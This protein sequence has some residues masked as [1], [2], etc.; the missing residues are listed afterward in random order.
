MV[1]HCI[2]ADFSRAMARGFWAAGLGMYLL[3]LAGMWDVAH[4]GAAEDILSLNDVYMNTTGMRYIPFV[5]CAVPMAYTFCEDWDNQFV[6]SAVIRA[7]VG[8][9]AA[10]RTAVTALAGGGA[11]V[12]GYVL[13]W[14]T[15]TIMG[16]P[17]FAG[18]DFSTMAGMADNPVFGWMLRDGYHALL[19][20]CQALTYGAGFAM[21]AVFALW[22]STRVPNPFVVTAAPVLLIIVLNFICYLFRIPHWYSFEGIFFHLM[23][24]G[25]LP[26]W[27]MTAIPIL[28]SAILCGLMGSLFADGVKRRLH[29]G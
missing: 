22:I 19:L 9:Y 26:A 29:H 8:R 13:Y 23:L 28:I 21:F 11:I 5:L 14:I 27:A 10:A 15:L 6:R 1:F 3:L 4:I 7:S 2:R 20:F 25:A 12:L 24:P 16:Y 17:V 18:R